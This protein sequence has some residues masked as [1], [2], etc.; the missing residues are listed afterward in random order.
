PSGEPIA[1][2]LSGGAR[3]AAYDPGA[4]QDACRVIALDLA[5]H[6]SWR[7]RLTFG[8]DEAQAARDADALVIVTE[9]KACKSPD[10]V[11]L[12]RLW[13][14]PVI[15]DGRNLY[16]PETRSEEGSQDHPIGRPGAR[17]A[18]GARGPGGAAA[19]ATAR[20]RSP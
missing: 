10:F 9:W 16:E 18:G 13:T 20:I 14:T 7:E 4:E 17:N 6:P 2:L 15:F 5:D 8:D 12:G 3:G 1:E 19:R 11:A